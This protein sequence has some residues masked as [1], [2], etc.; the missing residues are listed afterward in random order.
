MQFR[1][2]RDELAGVCWLPR[3]IDKA[4]EHLDG[5]LP[6]EYT[7]GF[8]NPR[9]M[10]GLF[11][12]SFSIS[13]EEFL[14]AVSASRGDDAQIA[15]W[16]STQAGVTRNK[17][18]GWNALA[19]KIGAPGQR[20]YEIFSKLVRERYPNTPYTG[21]ESVFEIIESDEPTSVPRTKSV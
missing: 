19:P 13:K 6:S 15:K 17:I 18:A 8:C 2:P 1:S 7:K 10:D 3:F 14:D 20:G 16:F 9:A 12:A 5:N 11:L 4:R 21:V